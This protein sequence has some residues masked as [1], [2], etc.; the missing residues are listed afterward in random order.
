MAAR[1]INC[2]VAFGVLIGLIKGDLM[3]YGM[4]LQMDRSNMSIGG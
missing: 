4:Y 3:T 2:H 1:T